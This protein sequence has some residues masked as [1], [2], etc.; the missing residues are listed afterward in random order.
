MYTPWVSFHYILI[1]QERVILTTLPA[2][3]S[4]TTI[5][6]NN[7]WMYHY[8]Y[9]YFHLI[10]THRVDPYVHQTLYNS[11]LLW[12]DCKESSGRVIIVSWGKRSG[13]NRHMDLFHQFMILSSVRRTCLTLISNCHIDYLIDLYFSWLKLNKCND[14]YR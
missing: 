4:F 2:E 6:Q 11:S 9:I 8:I 12:S 1:G 7:F 5:I 3:M 10:L 13:K 14:T